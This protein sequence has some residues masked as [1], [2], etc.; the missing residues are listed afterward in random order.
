[1]KI[2]QAIGF[3]FTMSEKSGFFYFLFIN[4]VSL[5]TESWFQHC[6]SGQICSNVS[7]IYWFQQI[8]NI[9]S[10]NMIFINNFFFYSHLLVF[11]YFHCDRTRGY[12]LENGRS[13]S[14]VLVFFQII[15][16]NTDLWP[17]DL[18]KNEDGDCMEGRGLAVKKLSGVVSSKIIA[19]LDNFI[20]LALKWTFGDYNKR[21]SKW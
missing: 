17:R 6:I 16:K 9:L 7:G 12:H 21:R 15:I 8:S 2:N 3:F 18:F 5:T 11:F 4:S 19:N 10:R 13:C 20:R 1:M 14:L